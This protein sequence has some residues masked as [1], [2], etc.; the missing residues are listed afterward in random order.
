MDAA[1]IETF[2]PSTQRLGPTSEVERVGA[3][4]FAVGSDHPH[5]MALGIARG[6]K[7]CQ[8]IQTTSLIL[9]DGVP[10]EA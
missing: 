8:H 5:R 7:E 10:C 2:F 4:L 6:R 9:T 1:L 3:Q